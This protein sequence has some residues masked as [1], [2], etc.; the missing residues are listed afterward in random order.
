MMLGESKYFFAS[1]FPN[2]CTNIKLIIRSICSSIP[3]A[4]AGYPPTGWTFKPDPA[5]EAMRREAEEKD[6]RERQRRE[7]ERLRR[8]KEERERR[9]KEKEEKARKEAQERER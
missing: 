4:V 5:I 8:E 7:E 9:E 1:E 2:Q 6:A 3:R